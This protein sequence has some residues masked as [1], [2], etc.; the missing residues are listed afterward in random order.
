[1]GLGIGLVMGLGMGFDSQTA[2]VDDVEGGDQG[3][4]FR[5]SGQNGGCPGHAGSV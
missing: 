4:R 1:M 3:P 5:G 2:V